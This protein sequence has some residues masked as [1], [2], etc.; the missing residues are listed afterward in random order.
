MAKARLA[1][2]TG[3]FGALMLF[4]SLVERAAGVQPVTDPFEVSGAGLSD[5]TRPEVAASASGPFVVSWELQAAGNP[6]TSIVARFF[7]AD[8]SPRGGHGFVSPF[9]N[10]G[11]TGNHAI[12]ANPDGAGAVAYEGRSSSTLV[13][14]HARRFD[15][16]SG[17][18]LGT[19]DVDSEMFGVWTNPAV[20][21]DCARNLAF[22]F[23][24]PGTDLDEDTDRRVYA[25][26][27]GAGGGSAG[28]R[29]VS[30]E[31]PDAQ[32]DPAVAISPAGDRIVVA[33]FM[34]VGVRARLF[35]AN[36]DP[37]GNDD[38]IVDLGGSGGAELHRELHAGMAAD[39]D[40]V[41]AWERPAGL[42]DDRVVVA[43]PYNAD[44]T[45]KRDEIGVGSAGGNF[46]MNPSLGVAANG[47]FAVSWE[48]NGFGGRGVAVKEYDAAGEPSGAEFFSPSNPPGNRIW[49]GLASTPLGRLV[50]AYTRE[51][52]NI[53]E[54]DRD[55]EVL[56]RVL[57]RD[58]DDHVPGGGGCTDAGGNNGGGNGGGDNGGGNNGGG[59]GGGGGGVAVLDSVPPGGFAIGSR[60]L[61]LDAKNRVKIVVNGP[62]NETVPSSGE[63]VMV[64]AGKVQASARR[65]VRLART[66]FAVA[67]GQRK[68]VTLKLTRKNAKLVRRLRRVQ[69]RLSVKLTDSAGNVSTPLTKRLRLKAAR[70]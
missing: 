70:R 58:L 57:R 53:T 28:P 43:R 6:N 50:V 51:D 1:L 64:T 39:G 10:N 7:N 36:L 69:V 2:R 9:P 67:P 46:D 30:S 5:H 15:M 49:P 54:S 62:A 13:Q 4:C 68:V 32:T 63:A 8:A 37:I 17:L 35:D 14:V 66:R 16:E 11:D 59:G 23:E 47:T 41:L 21:A 44:G 20:A 12:G 34:P 29:V 24:G 61:T 27:I 56:G 40:F 38:I 52:P 55:E 19:L 26:W 33:W 42:G 18:S 65:R 45:P 22:A 31:E 48:V 60:A 25:R 3:A